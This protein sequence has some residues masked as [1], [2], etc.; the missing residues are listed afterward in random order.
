VTADPFQKYRLRV[1]IGGIVV[2][3]Q[4]SVYPK[5]D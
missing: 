4:P 1:F 3:E 5:P 2:V